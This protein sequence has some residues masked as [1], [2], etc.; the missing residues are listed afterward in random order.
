MTATTRSASRTPSSM[1]LATSEAS[2]T[3]GSGTLRTSIGAGTRAPSWVGGPPA[4]AGGRKVLLQDGPD[5]AAPDGVG[6]VLEGRDD[7]AAAASLDEPEC[8]LDLRAHAAARELPRSR[9]RAQLGGGD[10]LQ[11]PGRRRPEVDHHVRDVGRDDQHLRLEFP[12]EQ[13]RGQVLVDD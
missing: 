2:L 5:G 7:G 13:G 4:G 6:D 1:S 12:G 8:G 11:R 10:A 9:V 3:W